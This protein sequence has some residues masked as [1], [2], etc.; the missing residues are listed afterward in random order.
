MNTKRWKAGEFNPL[1]PDEVTIEPKP[2]T[3]PTPEQQRQE[4]GWTARFPRP[5]AGDC[6]DYLLADRQQVWDTAEAKRT[7]TEAHLAQRR[8]ER[9]AA[10]QSQ[11]VVSAKAYA[12][13]QNAAAMHRE[14]ELHAIHLQQGGTEMTWQAEKDEILKADRR[15]RTL[16]AEPPVRS[17]IDVRQVI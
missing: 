11:R 9:A 15:Q 6:P 14:N 12:E 13:K 10:E 2:R 5:V 16:G 1:G 7:E 8:A 3:W 17:L 4:Y